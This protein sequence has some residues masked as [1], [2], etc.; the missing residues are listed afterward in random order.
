MWIKSSSQVKGHQFVLGSEIYKLISPTLKSLMQ[1][2]HLGSLAVEMSVEGRVES[3][4]SL[5]RLGFSI[6]VAPAA[7]RCAAALE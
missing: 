4:S 7:A 5:M 1:L 6:G 2:I 3:R